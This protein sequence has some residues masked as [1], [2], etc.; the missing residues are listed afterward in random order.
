MVDLI[1]D[2][3]IRGCLSVF[4][5]ILILKERTADQQSIPHRQADKLSSIFV[6]GAIYEVY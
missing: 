1:F 3:A 2:G 6:D 5:D 4:V